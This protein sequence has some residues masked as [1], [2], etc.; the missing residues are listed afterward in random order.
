M[1]LVHRALNLVERRSFNM[2]LSTLDAL[3][4]AAVGG[5][6]TAAGVPVSAEGALSLV[7]VNA[8]VGVLSE[9][10]ASTPLIT[11]KR[12]ARGK[13]RAPDHPLYDLLHDQPNPELTSLEYWDL[14]VG[15]AAT[16]G[17]HYSEI[18]RTPYGVTGLWP[19]RPDWMRV[20]RDAAGDLAYVYS[21]PGLQPRTFPVVDIFHVR[22]RTRDGVLGIS[23]I[24]QAREAIGL[25]GAAEGFGA[26]FFGNDSRPGGILSVEGRLTDEGAGRLK[27][28]WEAMHAGGQN[29]W[30]VAV[31]ENGV[32]W[33]QVGIPPADAQFLETRK[34]QRTEIAALFRVP[35]H[36]IGDL[37]RATFSNI[38]QQ[39]IEF[40]TYSLRPW[41][42]RIEKAVLRDLFRIT[43]GKRSH[44]AEFLIDGLLR[45]DA[46]TR[47][48]AL[49][50]QR[51]NGVITANEWREIENRNPIDGGD[52]LL[53]NGNMIPVDQAASGGGADMQKQVDS[54]GT[55]IRSGFD[56]QASLAAMGLP[57]IDHL[58]LLPITVQKPVE[59]D[60]PGTGPV[61]PATAD[62]NQPADAPA[63]P[64][65]ANEPA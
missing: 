27:R 55:L 45:G 43:A 59:V 28:A 65:G 47:A 24:A 44:F 53:V 20:T 14:V 6:P 40:V 7:P 42:V 19:L 21:Q 51:Q 61:T 48:Q 13:D 56:P 12:L 31:L 39:S 38:E 4:D 57:P 5:R 50:I 29:R 15:H 30:R 2:P 36:M 41:M 23:R 8:A 58:G 54:V 46:Y 25:A 10:V 63:T 1:N 60:T 35:P 52:G 49:A 37:E 17:N 22:D 33:Q 11:Y 16:W 18:E 34:F 32:T 62:P 9:G 3:M 26:R 64:G